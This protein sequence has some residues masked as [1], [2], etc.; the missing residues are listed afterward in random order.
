MLE[1]FL[2]GVVLGFS[3]GMNPG[4]LT[5]LVI[6]ATLEG[7]MA[8]GMRVAIAP[9]ITDLP[10]I[11][12]STLLVRALPAW[13]EIGLATVGGIYL[14]W[15]GYKTIMRARTAAPPSSSEVKTNAALEFRQGIF[16]NFLSPNP[17]I[18]WITVGAPLLLSAWAQSPAAAFAFVLGFYLLLV[19]G[20]IAIALLIAL[21]RNRLNLTLYRAI[22]YAS[23]GLLLYLGVRLFLTGVS[24]AL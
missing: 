22:F 24:A 19:G 3:A 10:I 2:R 7:G 20:K 21:T 18:F 16:V 5:S 23:G 11:L 12:I 14:L 9:L 8:S 15:L 6:T 1:S 17:W 4:P 13:A